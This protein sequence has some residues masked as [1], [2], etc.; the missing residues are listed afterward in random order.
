MHSKIIV[1][2]GTIV[3]ILLSIV[4]VIYGQVLWQKYSGLYV[5]TTPEVQNN[6]APVTAEETEG[7][8]S[9][10]EREE[11]FQKLQ[12]ATHTEMKEEERTAVYNNLTK[13]TPSTMTEEQKQEIIKALKTNN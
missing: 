13:D 6:T 11:I 9:T 12:N 3:T 8:L 4:L 10:Q 7:S 1:I 5:P 2:A